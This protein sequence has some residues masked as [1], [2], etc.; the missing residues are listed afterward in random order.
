MLQGRRTL[1]EHES[2][3]VLAEYG[4]P[5]TRELLCANPREAAQAAKE[6]GFP[7]VMKACGAN[8]QHKTDRGLVAVGVSTQREVRET[9]ERLTERAG[10]ADLDGVLVTEMVTGGVETVIGIVNDELFGPAV[11]FGLGGIAVE[12]FRDVTFRVP[13]FGKPE[14]S[15]M[16]REITSLPLLTGARGNPRA[17]LEA[18]ATTIMKVQRLAVELAGDIAELDINPLL[19]LPDRAVA[20]DALVVAR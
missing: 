10:N 3:S 8:L 13:P 17:D 6:I 11:M 14:A 7:I 15:R 4:I 1:S 18:L 12:V 2:K 16:I 20:L 19:A 5:V 9:Y